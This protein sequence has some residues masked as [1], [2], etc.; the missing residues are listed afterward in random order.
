MVDGA[1]QDEIKEEF[2]AVLANC[3]NSML[4]PYVVG[5]DFNILRHGGREEYSFHSF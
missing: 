1:A 2:L 4:C 3:C 5:G